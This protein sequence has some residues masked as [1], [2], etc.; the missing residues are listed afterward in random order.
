MGAEGLSTQLSSITLLK[1]D[2]LSEPE[3]GGLGGACKA[4]ARSLGRS[5]SRL[6]CV[7]PG[8]DQ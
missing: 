8:E 2:V 6:S 5:R 1:A 4:G 3:P 7:E